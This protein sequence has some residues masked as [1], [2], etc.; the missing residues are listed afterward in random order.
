MTLAHAPR[1]SEGVIMGPI[2]SSTSG[3]RDAE[4]ARPGVW[5][6]IWL[7]LSGTASFFSALIGAELSDWWRRRRSPR[8]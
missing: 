4:A 5:R 3:S 6:G 8:R 7:A 1:E 2:G